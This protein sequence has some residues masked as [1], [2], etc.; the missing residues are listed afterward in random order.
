MSTIARASD[1]YAEAIAKY[2]REKFGL[3]LPEVLGRIRVL[4]VSSVA[5]PCPAHPGCKRPGRAFLVAFLEGDGGGEALEFRKVDAP[6]SNCITRVAIAGGGAMDRRELIS[7]GLTAAQ[8]RA[9]I[10]RDP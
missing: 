9:L 10:P 5:I 7:F 2:D 1:I 3:P 8:A 4:G 6:C